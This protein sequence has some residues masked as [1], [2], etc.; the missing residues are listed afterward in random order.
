MQLMGHNLLL[1]V[2]LG[3]AYTSHALSAGFQLKQQNAAGAA[4]AYAGEAARAEDAS[5]VFFNPAGMTR[6]SGNQA[7]V[8]LHTII[9]HISF[10]GITNFNAKHP[11]MQAAQLGGISFDQGVGSSELSIDGVIPNIY[12]IYNYTKDLKFG[13]GLNTPFGLSS[14][15][16]SQ[17]M[18][19]YHG[20]ESTLKTLNFNPSVGYRFNQQWSIGGGVNLLYAYSN[21][22]SAVDYN[23]IYNLARFQ[24][25]Q[26]ANLSLIPGQISGDGIVTIEGNDWGFGFNL[27]LLW[28]PTPVTRLGITY[29]SK[30]SLDMKG[31]SSFTNPSNLSSRQAVEILR[32]AT[33]MFKNSGVNTNIDLPETIAISFYHELNSKLAILAGVN[34]TKWSRLENLTASFENPA[35]ANSII[36]LNYNNTFF[37]ALGFNYKYNSNWILKSGI[38]YDQ[39]HVKNVQ[40]HTVR[41]PLDDYVLFGLGANYIVNKYFSIDLAYSH[42]FSKDIEIDNS[43]NYTAGTYPAGYH[44]IKGTYNGSA[45]MLS[46]QFNWKF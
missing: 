22:S 20:I 41:L 7:S 8:A 11:T 32:G 1:I 15:Y 10:G 26:L 18:G 17:W 37:T 16:N 24:N 21:F 4:N 35:Q 43:D 23:L 5:T 44:N 12:Y 14:K 3:C 31:N 39:S 40:S 6:L 9:P 42:L 33:G 19:R 30:I 25:S 34:W 28:E 45:D 38:G 36:T 46:I 27:G 2:I 13:I 29:R